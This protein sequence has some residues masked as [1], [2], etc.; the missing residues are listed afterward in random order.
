MPDTD[1]ESLS[2]RVRRVAIASAS[3]EVAHPWEEKSSSRTGPRRRCSSAVRSAVALAS[4]EEERRSLDL[5]PLKHVKKRAAIGG[6]RERETEVAEVERH[7]E[8]E[9]RKGKGGK[10]NTRRGKEV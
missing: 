8:S 9:I 5:P 3:G 1:S 7:E 10:R 6:E 2:G 4:G